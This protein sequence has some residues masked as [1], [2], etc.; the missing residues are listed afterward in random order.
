MKMLLLKCLVLIFGVTTCLGQRRCS[1]DRMRQCQDG[2]R[3]SME[4]RISDMSRQDLPA[5]CSNTRDDF[6]CLLRETRCLSENERQR[7]ANT[8]QSALRYIRDGCNVKGGYWKDSSCFVGDDMKNCE[9]SNPLGVS[10][11]SS[12]T[13]DSCRKYQQFYHCVHDVVR[14]RCSPDDERLIGLYLL[15]TAQD[16]AWNCSESDTDSDRYGSSDRWSPDRYGGG[17]RHGGSNDRYGGSDRDRYG[18]SSDRYGG[19]DRDRYGGSDRDRY[20]GSSDRYGGSSDRYGGSD[21]G[22]NRNYDRGY[23]RGYD[24][25][26]RNHQSYGNNG[27]THGGPSSRNDGPPFDERDR[28]I[29]CCRHERCDRNRMQQCRDSLSRAI[30]NRMSGYQDLQKCRKARDDFN[31]LLWQN[32]C[33]PSDEKDRNSDIFHRAKDYLTKSCD[34]YGRWNENSCYK[35][36]DMQRCENYLS[37][38]RSGTDYEACRSYNNFRECVTQE[39]TNRCTR[40][41]ELLQGAYFVDKAQEMAWTCTQD[42]T[43]D[44][45]TY[46]PGDRRNFDDRRNENY[47]PYGSSNDDYPPRLDDDDIECQRKVQPQADNCERALRETRRQLLTESNYDIKQKKT[48]CSAR[49]YES[50]LIAATQRICQQHRRRV[51]ESLMGRQQYELRSSN[52]MRVYESDCNSSSALAAILFHVLIGVLVTSFTTY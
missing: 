10:S 37:N 52:C 8:L 18:G 9:N 5:H 16:L 48:C 21:R 33:L 7:N 50:C 17:D 3:R 44:R 35:S 27:S 12:Y 45:N 42:H 25:Y 15:E 39:L 51:V 14:N 22:S 36:S 26:D 1:Y 23:D 34:S 2:L 4:K 31:C 46:Y 40:E 47:P 29:T 24:R 49:D 38:T 6:N 19:S 30:D 43:D 11:F 28:D 41:D 13:S 20:G 32:S